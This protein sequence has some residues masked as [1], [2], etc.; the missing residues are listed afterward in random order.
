MKTKT[1]LAGLLPLMLSAPVFA[2]HCPVDMQKI[3]AA[4]AANP[5]LSETQLA[6]IRYLRA[7]GEEYHRAGQHQR[8]VDTLARAMQILRIQ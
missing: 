7:E 1:L 8:S 2:F 3:D 4:L 5:P 6:E